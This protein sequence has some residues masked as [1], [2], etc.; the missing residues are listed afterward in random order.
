MHRILCCTIFI[1]FISIYELLWGPNR[2]I[3]TPAEYLLIYLILQ[4]V[5]LSILF[6]W[7]P[8]RHSWMHRIDAWNVKLVIAISV[9]YTLGFKGL[10]VNDKLLYI[11]LCGLL[12]WTY[13]QSHYYSSQTWCSHLHIIYHAFLHFVGGLMAVITLS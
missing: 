8:V 13:Y 3:P 10:L 12:A 1:L 4:T 11:C 5:F 6:W 2:R 9:I 7:N